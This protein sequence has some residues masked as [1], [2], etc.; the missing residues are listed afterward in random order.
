MSVIIVQ[1][2]CL[3]RAVT[4]GAP[5]DLLGQGAVFN[6]AGVSLV[7]AAKWSL[8]VTTTQNVT[9]NVYK[10]AGPNAGLSILS[11]LTTVVT[12]TAPLTVEFEGEANQRIRV[13]AI[14]VASTAAVNCD[15][16][17]VSP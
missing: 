2:G 7:N 12:S 17:A 5:V 1:A 13:T 15:F 11:A 3:A 14:A 10:G 9:V 4:S 8:I 6:A 16:R